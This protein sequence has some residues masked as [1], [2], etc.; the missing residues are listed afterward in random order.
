[1]F[2]SRRR[3]TI[4]LI[5][6]NV[7][8]Q[9]VRRRMY[10]C[11]DEYRWKQ[12]RRCWRVV[13]GEDETFCLLIVSRME[14]HKKWFCFSSIISHSTYDRAKLAHHGQRKRSNSRFLNK[15]NITF[16]TIYHAIY[17]IFLDT[18]S[19]QSD[20]LAVTFASRHSK[21]VACLLWHSPLN[22]KKLNLSIA[23]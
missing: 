22:E 8:Q 5:L 17:I 11:V 23:S 21:K 2:A 6:D 3:K 9:C 15:C 14:M 4:F 19:G 1:M 12:H 16:A 13:E 18:N 10:R 7:E 20:R